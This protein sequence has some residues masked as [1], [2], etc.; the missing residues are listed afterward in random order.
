MLDEK[1]ADETPVDKISLN[2]FES[3]GK[4]LAKII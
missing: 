1:M 3:T 4:W 2:V